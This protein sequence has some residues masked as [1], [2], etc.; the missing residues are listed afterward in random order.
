MCCVCVCDGRTGWMPHAESTQSSSQ[1]RRRRGRK[2]NKTSATGKARVSSFANCSK[3]AGSTKRLRLNKNEPETQLEVLRLKSVKKKVRRKSHKNATRKMQPKTGALRHLHL[4]LCRLPFGRR[5]T[6]GRKQRGSSDSTSRMAFRRLCCGGRWIND[7]NSNNNNNGVGGRGQ[8]TS[9][10]AEATHLPRPPTRVCRRV[11]RRRRRLHLRHRPPPL[12]SRPQQQSPCPTRATVPCTT[13]LQEQGQRRLRQAR[14]CRRQQRPP[15]SPAACGAASKAEGGGLAKRPSAASAAACAS[16]AA[17]AAA[18]ATEAAAPVA[19][20]RR[21]RPAPRGDARGAV[22]LQ[23]PPPRST[24]T[25]R[26]RRRHCRR[27]ARQSLQQSATRAQ[28]ADALAQR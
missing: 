6:A 2:T 14:R 9:D 17:A 27:R 7:R 13:S 22:S 20:L 21:G 25:L 23:R 4:P 18:A 15:V 28:R 3:K 5:G 19:V 24:E 26:L 16:A 1:G 12:P 11:P 8:R 10:I